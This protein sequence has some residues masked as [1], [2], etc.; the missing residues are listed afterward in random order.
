MHYLEF[1]YSPAVCS[2]KQI[3]TAHCRSPP[4]A[5]RMAGQ[6]PR[7]TL[8]KSAT[9]STPRRHFYCD[10]GF[11]LIEL[12]VVISIIA[13]LVGILLPAL[14]SARNAAKG[15]QCKSL[16][17]QY[18]TTT[19]CYCND[20]KDYML[21][22]YT[23]FNPSSGI[24]VYWVGGNGELTEE[25]TRCP[26]DDSTDG[27]GRTGPVYYNEAVKPDGNTNWDSPSY[28]STGVKC[29]IGGNENILSATGR[30]TRNGY[31]AMW[32]RRT[33]FDNF[34]V[35]KIGVWADWQNNPVE[36]QV[37]RVF[38]TPNNGSTDI[39]SAV[40]RHANSSNIAYL[41]GHVGAMVAEFQLKNDGHNLADGASYPFSSAG[42]FGLSTTSGL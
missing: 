11:T 19:E 40:F 25:M 18:A 3:P 36:E 5:P 22:A 41:D 37:S 14:S 7:S 16:L 27:L 15:V 31:S 29:S 30:R 4:G 13:L 33:E 8:M 9:F 20:Y 24:A 1:F 28:A 12:L 32:V 38:W 21:D 42:G 23:Y 6:T 26:G 2:R 35:S 17:R 39:G 10:A 34:Q